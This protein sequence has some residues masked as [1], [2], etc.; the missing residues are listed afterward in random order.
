MTKI[1]I[2]RSIH[3]AWKSRKSWDHDA[4]TNIACKVA[5]QQ[6]FLIYH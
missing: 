3:I 6:T 2:Y 1:D 5:K 4:R